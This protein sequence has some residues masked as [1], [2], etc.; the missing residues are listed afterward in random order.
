[1]KNRVILGAPLAAALLGAT[2]SEQVLAQNATAQGSTET[3]EEITVTGTRLATKDIATP[4]PVQT[5]TAEDIEQKAP[6]AIADVVNQIPAFRVTRSSS[7]SGRV[8]DQQSGV[9]ALLDLRG[10]D[11]VRTLVLIDGQR[12]V[13]TNAQGT[14]DSNMIPVGLID[15]VDV[16]TG[17]AS[18]AY[19]SDAVSGVVN[20]VL[21]HNLEGIRGSL[22]SGITRYGDGAQNVATLAGGF[23]FADGRG[24]VIA[25]LDAAK[26]NGVGNIYTRPYGKSEPGLLTVSAAQRAALGLPAQVFAN[27]VELA[28]VTPGGL[29]NTVASDGNYYAFDA[30]GNPYAY[31]RG[32]VFGSGASANT[33]GNSNYGYNSAGAFQLQSKNERQ[34]AYARAEF[35]LTPEATV[36]AS[37]NWGHT[38]LPPQLTAFY[39]QLV[40]VSTSMLPTALQ[41]EYSTST[42]SVGR[43][44]TDGDGG[45][46]TWQSNE[47]KRGVIGA[48]G[49]VFGDWNWDVSYESG[50][51]NQSFNTSGL[52]LSA[53]AKAANG[54]STATLTTAYA[55]AVAKYEALTGKSCVTYDIF[56]L[57]NSAAAQNYIYDN[58]HQG[59]S[60]GQDAAQASISGSPLTLWAGD[61]QLAA[62]LEWRRD[63]LDVTGN[64]LG[65]ANLF[66]QGNFGSYTGYNSVKEMF[67]ELGLPVLRNLPFAKAVD[68][69]GAV[70]RTDYKNG[71]LVTTWKGGATWKPVDSLTLRATK[72]RDIRAPNLNELYFIGGALPGSITYNGVTNGNVLTNGQGNPD[73]K[74]EKADTFTTGFAFQPA[75]GALE[76]FRSSVDFYKIKVKG[77]IVRL[78]TAQTLTQCAE[79]IAAGSTTCPGI[80]FS[81]TPSSAST[82]VSNIYSLS[83]LSENL[84]S[85]NVEGLDF[86]VGYRLRELPFNLPGSLDFNLLLNHAINDQQVLTTANGTRTYELAG[87]MNGVPDWNGNLTIG[88]DLGKFGAD[89]QLTGFTGV[90]YDALT[91]YLAG[92]T[93]TYTGT[94]VD[95]SD[96]SYLNTNDNTIN[97]NHFGGVV[98]S[99]VSAHYDFNDHLQVFGAINNLF[100]RQPPQYAIIA[101]TNGSRNLNYDL[102][103][104]AFKL[105]VRFNF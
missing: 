77:A 94:L 99:N 84:N 29:I 86:E 5:L 14:F 98:Y 33:I 69:N 30:S 39:S 28:N 54:C 52:V 87:S 40:N 55:T 51:V 66:S 38:H 23:G 2:L 93:Q 105:G 45:N 65:E 92:T 19:G 32:T 53:L 61:L 81:S 25:G 27:G 10:L 60:F 83:N 85:L 16:V 42:V 48:N 78:S 71:G 95:P 4:T 57:S 13:G 103:G 7:G 73:L 41:S 79:L 76:G 49:K 91:L 31:N 8:A 22:Q 18:A 62:G 74:P 58:Q 24:H 46:A 68:L 70:R 102:L 89:W 80:V 63:S 59:S 101:V 6:V 3:L 47:L 50:R 64:A 34:A 96:A 82:F 15:R 17:G 11:P 90:K 26:T 75:D 9:S 72:S 56:G 1:M 12:T 36:Y 88:Y 35:E 43:I 20:F 37:L 97:Q 67:T 44:F 100:D 104:R 21:K